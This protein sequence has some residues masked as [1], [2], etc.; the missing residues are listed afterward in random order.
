MLL[1][2]TIVV[3]TWAGFFAFTRYD[4]KH[5]LRMYAGR[6]SA[7]LALS[8]L[9]FSSV[10]KMAGKLGLN[11]LESLI[12]KA[13]SDPEIFERVKNEHEI[14][15]R[16]RL[17]VG[18]G[19]ML[20]TFDGKPV[21]VGG[22]LEKNFRRS[23]EYFEPVNEIWLT[24]FSQLESRLKETDTGGQIITES[25]NIDKESYLTTC[26]RLPSMPSET[27]VY[28]YAEKNEILSVYGFFR[29][30][31]AFT[32]CAFA[33]TALALVTGFLLA[34]GIKREIK[35]SGE[36]K[37]TA[38]EL[39]IQIE[40]R[41]KA[42][43]QREELQQQLMQA[44]KMEAIGVLAG[45]IAHNFNNMLTVIMGNAELGILSAEPGERPHETLKKIFETS[46]KARSFT[47]KLL[48]FSRDEKLNVQPV[49]VNTLILEIINML[50]RT[51]DKKIKITESLEINSPLVSADSNQMEQ[52]FLNIAVNA[53]ESMVDGGEITFESFGAVIDEKSPG[54]LPGVAPGKYCLVTISDTGLGIP[55]ENLPKV[56]DPFFTTKEKEKG[57]GL[58]LSITD[59]IVKGHGGFIR[60]SSETGKGTSVEV[61]L[62][63]SEETLPEPAN[64]EPGEQARGTETI[65]VVDDEPG[66]LEVAADVLGAAGY[67]ILTAGGGEE[68]LSTFKQNS[69]SLD[70]VLL[71]WNMPDMNGTEVFHALENIDPDVKVVLA[72]GYSE[73]GKAGELLSKG[74]KHFVQKPFSI[75]EL[76]SAIRKALDE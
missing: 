38:D 65:L 62:P 2:F 47:L 44:Q 59:R 14:P 75:S 68:A 52:A 25:I 11:M 64:G 56:L 6:Q 20:I 21:L 43:K 16:D 39:K 26:M 53:C 71:D 4:E 50:K 57:T 61:Y 51:V 67:K 60:I 12:K 22:P 7:V 29:R 41:K 23:G 5:T 63:A 66:V 36:L 69:N 49:S 19:N 54:K 32:I 13:S 76:N 35:S 72:S 17:M 70:L 73:S 37:R 33:F 45:G 40:D 9:A 46:K 18:Y 8:Y 24:P 58:G 31:T 55:A 42:E 1:V 3:L 74:V 34:G 48:T 15:I 10:E 28:L 27:V 30:R